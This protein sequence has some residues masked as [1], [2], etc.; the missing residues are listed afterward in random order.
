M[1]GYTRPGGES[2]SP[3]QSRLIEE[4]ATNKIMYLGDPDNPVEGDMRYV[5]LLGKI[6][7]ERYESNAWVFESTVAGGSII[8]DRFICEGFLQGIF[9]GEDSLARLS[10]L[11]EKTFILSDTD[12]HTILTGVGDIQYVQGD[13][14]LE[15]S[16]PQPDFSE[17][18]TT[19]KMEFWTTPSA[20]EKVVESIFKFS[21]V[22]MASFQTVKMRWTAYSMPNETGTKF[23]ESCSQFNYDN[24]LGECSLD[25]QTGIFPIEKPLYLKDFEGAKVYYTIY[26]SEVLTYLG[27]NVSTPPDMQFYPY[28]EQR[29]YNGVGKVVA[30][31]DWV[32]ETIAT[33]A[34]FKGVHVDLTALQTAFPT[35]IAGNT[36]TV[37]NPDGNLFYW[38]TISEAWED[39]GTGYI[40]DMLKF[41]F[42]P[43]GKNADA[44]SMGNMAETATKKILTDA[45]R[46]NLGNQSNT[47][48]GDQDLSGII[49]ALRDVSCKLRKAT[50]QTLGSTEY[51]VFITWSSAEKDTDNMFDINTSNTEVNI[52]TA[53]EYL[54]VLQ[55][56]WQSDSTGQRSF[57]LL[58]NGTQQGKDLYVPFSTADHAFTWTGKL[59]V[60]DNIKMIA[61]QESNGGNLD[62]LGDNNYL[63]VTKIS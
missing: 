52:N 4:W 5:W 29:D 42:D 23:H 21:A 39:T 12:Y 20:F 32:I 26:T 55:A 62:F 44:F 14:I 19:D 7:A 43:T 35:G 36:A 2:L 16:I 24:G 49:E 34:G 40:G 51:P 15:H 9:S 1:S 33:M 10:T 60:G 56:S 8:T 37:T 48:T 59:E 31:Q 38:N 57:I 47:N 28:N 58:I 17:E 46:I 30:L 50:D 54:V 45:E 18:L 3:L 27:A 61:F 41:I 6:D 25:V 22:T 63:A 53:G 11:T 13:G